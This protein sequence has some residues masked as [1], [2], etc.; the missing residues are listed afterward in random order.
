MP[1]TRQQVPKHI[2]AK[3][4]MQN[5]RSIARQQR[6][7][8]YRLCFLGV[9]AKWVQEMSFNA[10]SSEVVEE[11]KWELKEYKG[12]SLQNEDLMC[13]V[14]TVRLLKI[15]CHDTTSEYWED[16]VCTSDWWSG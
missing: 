7:Q 6:S 12:I 14:V 3:G 9:C 4:N 10:G 16:S 13:A 2:P 8:Q 15:R 11:W 1:I 5:N